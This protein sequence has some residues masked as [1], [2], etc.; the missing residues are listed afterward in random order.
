[1][2]RIL[3]IGLFASLLISSTSLIAEEEIQT[4]EIKKSVKKAVATF[5]PSEEKEISDVDKF[6]NMFTDGQ[7]SGQLEMMYAGYNYE[8]GDNDTYSTAIGGTLKYEL[9]ELNGFNGAVAFSV[10]HDVN[11]ATGDNLKQNSELSSTNGE[12]AELTEA[13]INYKYQDLNLRVGRQMIDTPLADSDDIRMIANTFE[14]YIATYKL[15][16]FELMA[17]NLQKWQGIDAGLDSAWDNKTG[18]DGTWFGGVT[19]AEDIVEASA[20]YYNITKLTNAAYFDVT[21]NYEINS[22]ITI[23]GAAQYLNESEIDNSGVEAQIYGFLTK[24]IAYDF[25]FHLAYNKSNKKIAKESF[26]G[27]GGGTLFTNMDTMILDEIANDRD[28][29]AIVVGISYHIDKWRALY[30]YGDFDGDA[31]SLGIKAH[32]VEQNMGFEYEV[33]EEFYVGVFYVIEEDKES[34]T[35]TGNDWNRVQIMAAYNF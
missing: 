5:A 31:N 4:R 35:K 17:A 12:Y 34:S 3:N 20:W 9:A 13:Y 7:V 15:D 25:G 2:N 28:A 11:F 8:N 18:E 26:S 27:F 23:L 30:A 32:I 16:S 33:D 14:A 24:A 22:D 29:S 1:M 21:I 10:S 19:Y 6:K